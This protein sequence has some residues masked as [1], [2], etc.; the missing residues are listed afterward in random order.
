MSPPILYGTLDSLLQLAQLYLK[1]SQTSIAYLN[2]A[3]EFIEPLKS[4][5]ANRLLASAYWNWSCVL[6]QDGKAG[7][8]AQCIPAVESCLRVAENG[9]KMCNESIARQPNEDL[10]KG[11]K[12]ILNI[13]I[14]Q[15]PKRY[16]LLAICYS[17]IHDNYS[18]Y[19]AFSKSIIYSLQMTS[20]PINAK[21]G[22][23]NDSQ[24]FQ[25][26]LKKAMHI[27][28][29]KIM[30]KPQELSLNSRAEKENVG[31][32]ARCRLI[33]LQVGQI[34]ERA[35][36]DRDTCSATLFM[37]LELIGPGG[38]HVDEHPLRRAVVLLRLMEQVVLGPSVCLH[39]VH[40]P[41]PEV[42]FEEVRSI[43]QRQDYR[44]DDSLKVY[45][46]SYMLS[47]HM[48]LAIYYYRSSDTALEGSSSA[49]REARHTKEIL[50]TLLGT[51]TQ[52]KSSIM[53]D[54]NLHSL[55][56][57]S[58]TSQSNDVP[59]KTRNGST[60]QTTV[61]RTTRS[62]AATSATSQSSKATT[63]RSTRPAAATRR[64]VKPTTT[65]SASASNMGSKDIKAADSNDN[66]V[67]D[68]ERCYNALRLL[69]EMLGILGHTF[70]RL[71]FL[72]LLRKL[73]QCQHRKCSNSAED[74]LLASTTLAA[75]Y[76]KIGKIYRA[77]A[78]FAQVATMKEAPI[79]K[80]S[81]SWI[82]SQIEF[83][84]RYSE[85]LAITGNVEKR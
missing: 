57:P 83:N 25:A 52:R 46:M 1:D 39:N 10:I 61:T 60:K 17:K 82:A 36:S 6:F 22:D 63:T 68:I 19:E 43:V 4:P 53:R 35:W 73:C 33:E 9:I 85:Y 34:E 81:E 2:R 45:T 44:N 18:A 80:T 59:P 51:G 56:P 72:K 47:A 16:E 54:N 62:R 32:D 7:T 26:L 50:K 65:K 14:D 75:E 70:L 15:R 8:E 28:L 41:A 76:V 55:V 48:Y 21:T 11:D 23:L 78:I 49:L 27:G 40:V 20:P 69:T 30:L 67:Y 42:I 71:D 38:Y 3:L 84:L 58:Q 66:L 37:L 13:M 74:Y 64:V 12:E 79:D 29:S 77:G 24:S 5:Q 31:K